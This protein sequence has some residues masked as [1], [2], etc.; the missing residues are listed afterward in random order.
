MVKRK[1][2]N[3]S[4][5]ER[6]LGGCRLRSTRRSS[7]TRLARQTPLSSPRIGE[8]G[9]TAQKTEESWTK[10]SMSTNKCSAF[11][12]GSVA[13]GRIVRDGSWADSTALSFE[14]FSDYAMR[15]ERGPSRPVCASSRVRQCRPES[16]RCT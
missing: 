7:V 14:P 8:I 15:R 11:L 10:E 12:T 5:Q 4:R 6:V 16:D 9:S 3:G 2:S 1:V 13:R